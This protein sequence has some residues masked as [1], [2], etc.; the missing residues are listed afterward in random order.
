MNVLPADERDR[1]GAAA[2]EVGDRGAGEPVSLVLELA[3]LDQLALRV[4]EPFEPVDRLGEL[5]RAALNQR[6]LRSRGVADVLDAVAHDL[7]G[8]VVDVIADVVEDR[9][10]AE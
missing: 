1:V 7:L 3:Q 9:R 4:L 10:E 2:E 5:R 6:G 8:G